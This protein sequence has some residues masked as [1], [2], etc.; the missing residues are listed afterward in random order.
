MSV[1]HSLRPKRL[2]TAL[3]PLFTALIS[4]EQGQG[5]L[6]YALTILA[7]L[8]PVVSAAMTYSGILANL[9]SH[10]ISIFP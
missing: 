9:Y 7:V 10:I 8:I 3:N 1:F 6:E 5:F 2:A 4:D